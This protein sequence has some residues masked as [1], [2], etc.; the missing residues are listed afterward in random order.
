MKHVAKVDDT[1][2]TK[3]GFQE[4]TSNA[5]QFKDTI[6]NTNLIIDKKRTS[7]SSKSRPS[8]EAENEE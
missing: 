6:L 3:D 1:V 2:V 7:F 4:D 5:D 8:A